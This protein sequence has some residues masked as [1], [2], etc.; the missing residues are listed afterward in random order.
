LLRNAVYLFYADT[1][2]FVCRVGYETKNLGGCQTVKTVNLDD[3]RGKTAKQFQY[4]HCAF[5]ARVYADVHA[6]G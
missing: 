6:T 4:G 2:R 1:I 5:V 3:G